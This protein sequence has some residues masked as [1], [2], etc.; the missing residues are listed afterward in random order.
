[1]A[2]N[3]EHAGQMTSAS[4]VPTIEGWGD[5][6]WTKAMYVPEAGGGI[7]TSVIVRTEGPYHS[8]GDSADHYEAI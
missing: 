1:M 7:G 6:Q 2:S 8:A 4:P 3:E 5:R